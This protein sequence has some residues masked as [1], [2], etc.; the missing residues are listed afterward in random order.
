MA[1]IIQV[2]K[3]YQ[4]A[5]V[6]SSIPYYTRIYRVLSSFIVPDNYNGD[7]FLGAIN[8]YHKIGQIFGLYQGHVRMQ[9]FLEYTQQ[10]WG[11]FIPEIETDLPIFIEQDGISLEEFNS[12]TSKHLTPNTQYEPSQGIGKINWG[13]FLVDTALGV[14][15]DYSAYA[16]T[17]S[18]RSFAKYKPGL[19]TQ[20]L[21]IDQWAIEVF[22][23][24]IVAELTLLELR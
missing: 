21:P 7:V 15:Q 22:R 14:A 4:S 3:G 8:R 17:R 18:M 23:D 13:R 10:D 12:S 2:G 11:T 1:S 16:L 5:V 19:Y 6:L 9:F 20:M 24:D